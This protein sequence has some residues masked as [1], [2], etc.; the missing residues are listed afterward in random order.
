MAFMNQEQKKVIAAELKKV[1][2]KGWKYS[3][4]VR[5]Y[6]TI[7][8]TFRKGPAVLAMSEDGE[9]KSHQTLSE[10]RIDDQFEGET[11][12]ALKAIVNVL[13]MNNYNNSDPM[14]DYFDVGHYVR[15]QAG[16]WDKPYIVTDDA[17]DATPEATEPA[18]TVELVEEVAADEVAAEEAP[19][20]EP[21]QTAEEIAAALKKQEKIDAYNDRKAARVERYETYAENAHKRSD[22]RYKAS[23]AATRGIPLG[24]P[25]LVGHHSE[26]AHRNALKRSWDNMG[27][28]VAETEK[29]EYW[30]R[31]AEAAA[32]NRAISSDNPEAV[33]LLQRKIEAAEHSQELMKAANKIAKS[34]RKNYT[35]EQ[36]IADL[37][38]A[39]YTVENASEIMK[40]DFMGRIGFP[41]YA[42]TNNNANIRRM[43]ERRAELKQAE[44]RVTHEQEHGDMTIVYEADE[45][46]I[47]LHHDSKP[48]AETRQ[49]IKQHGFKWS[50]YNT[51]WQRKWTQNAAYSTEQLIRALAA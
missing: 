31:R 43:K 41:S 20:V 29:A 37:Q 6:S 27:K 22:E 32:S 10:Y 35:I 34:R 13:N 47:Q 12:D 44:G 33:D 19:A 51:C 4:A 8:M 1:T 2:P 38:K 21:E 40:P 42:L 7:V 26:G 50:R 15:I 30:E 14:T 28:S 23:H 49:I 39:G 17:G 16:E 3:L 11:R 25:I 5:N 45:N 18:A 48:S 46:R 36:K 9:L 24:Q